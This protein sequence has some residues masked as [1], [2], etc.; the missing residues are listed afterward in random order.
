MPYFEAISS[1]LDDVDV[2]HF[3]ALAGELGGDLVDGRPKGPARGTP[4]G[5][6]IDDDGHAAPGDFLRPVLVGEFEDV[7]VS[8]GKP[9]G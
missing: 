3:A 4:R 6:E 5:P 2:A 9:P 8:H 1:L 7:F